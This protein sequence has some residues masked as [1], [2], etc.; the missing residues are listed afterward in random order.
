MAI[1]IVLELA[2]LHGSHLN[3]S[4]SHHYPYFNIGSSIYLYPTG[5]SSFVLS[6]DDI[7]DVKIVIDPNT[8]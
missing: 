4:I 8:N 6:Y 2:L 3:L 1:Q 7:Y 5:T